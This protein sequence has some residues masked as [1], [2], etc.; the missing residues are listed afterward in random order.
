MGCGRHEFC[1][2]ILVLLA[3]AH[4]KRL[5]ALQT[6]LFVNFELLQGEASM[7]DK[8]SEE[9]RKLDRLN[10]IFIVREILNWDTYR[11]KQIMS[12]AVTIFQIL[13]RLNNTLT[14]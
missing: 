8:V 11:R 9:G 13:K 5:E 6:V 2:D 10:D 4:A 3:S 7:F 12:T 1:H 14:C